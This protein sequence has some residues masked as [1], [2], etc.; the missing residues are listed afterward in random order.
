MA[1]QLAMSCSWLLD[2]SSVNV[3]MC[4]LLGDARCVAKGSVGCEMRLP[5]GHR[6]TH[7]P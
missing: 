1:A 3:D 7:Y 6:Q 2:S 4:G 5:Q